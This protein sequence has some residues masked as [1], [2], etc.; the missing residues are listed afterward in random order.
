MGH[1]FLESAHGE[2]ADRTSGPRNLNHA[3]LPFTMKG[4]N[5]YLFLDSK[6]SGVFPSIRKAPARVFR[7]HGILMN[8]VKRR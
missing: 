5:L 1:E 3:R 6:L 4:M 2:L 8:W 7:G